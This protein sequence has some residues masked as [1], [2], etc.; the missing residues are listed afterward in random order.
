MAQLTPV[1]KKT[2]D[3]IPDDRKIPNIIDLQ[4]SE[5]YLNRELTWL[6]FNKRVL[7]EGQ[8]PRNPL[9]ERV[10]FLAVVGSNLD[11][12]FM[13]RIGGLKQMVGASVKSLSLDGRL[14]QEQ[15]D[16][17]HAVVRDILDQ[18]LT[19]ENDL[20]RLLSRKNIKIK[21]YKD[22]SKE[23]KENIDQYFRNEIYPLLTPQGMDPAHPFPFISNLSVNLLVS[24]RYPESDH[25]YLNRIKIPTSSDLPRFIRIGKEHVYILLED[26]V[27]NNLELLLPG[28]E[29]ETCETFRV[30][31]NAITERHEEQANDLLVVIESALRDRK[32]AEIV[33][34]EIGSGMLEQHKGKLAAELRVDEAKDVYEVD[35]I[36][37]LR[38]LMQIAAIDRSDLHFAQ[39][40]P[41]DNPELLGDDPNIFHTIREHGDILLQ[42]PYE[43][44]DTSVERFLREASTDPKVMAI[45]MTLYRTAKD[46]K[47]IQYLIDAAQNGK[48]VAVVVELMARFDESANIRWAGFLEEAGIHV[49]YGVI[50]LKTHSKLIFVIR[51]DYNGLRRY[52]HIGTGNYH[53]GT[54]RGYCDLGLI[55]CDPEIGADLTELFNYLTSGYTPMRRYTKLLPSPKI[56]K[57]ALLN[58]IA[59]EIEHQ[60]KGKNGL[61][62]FKT[63]A[64][65]DR[66]IVEALYRASQA[67]VHADLIVRDS[68]RL[69]PGIKGL[70]DNLRVI[71][72]VGRFLE[73]SRIFYFHN[74]GDEEYYIGSA[75][76]MMRNLE[77]RVEV[78]APITSPQHKALLRELL[79]LQLTNTRNVWE[80][81]SDGSSVQLKS[82]S[83]KGATCIH[84][85]LIA[86][87]EKRAAAGRL[88][89]AK[90]RSKKKLPNRYNPEMMN[91]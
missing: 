47:I 73:H 15:I 83:E 78:C 7:H 13:K 34:L 38:D 59:R 24:V 71:S 69:R 45:K 19:L 65:V 26:L 11:E 31:R 85:H 25:S 20:Q 42:H 86:R 57:K 44:F 66:D 37:G 6:E 90:K 27:A 41:V 81:Q 77:S 29:V 17:C 51:K 23:D 64:L 53:A 3:K 14:P 49:T 22:L 79:D 50:G 91:K 9:L 70:S 55:T 46:S 88:A 18:Q 43:S 28:M 1:D 61:I 30:T 72:L 56:L 67:G 82:E 5:W 62:Q 63:N 76:L 80:I 32:F 52:A 2:T 16:L 8:D 60:K 54:A 36:L 87:A 21:K 4:A 58:K 39:H 12:F 48:Q 68:C 74:N 84:Q 35:G 33:R 75:D 10:F 89:L 40:H